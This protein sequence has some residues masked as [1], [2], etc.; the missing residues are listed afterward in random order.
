MD[1]LALKYVR[2]VK[3]IT[4]VDLLIKAL[5]DVLRAGKKETQSSLPIIKVRNEVN[6][7]ITTVIRSFNKLYDMVI[8]RYCPIIS[9]IKG[10]GQTAWDVFDCF[11]KI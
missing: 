3:N 9:V 7:Y 11:E 10:A 8:N 4:D 1:D 2:P 6:Q 5:E